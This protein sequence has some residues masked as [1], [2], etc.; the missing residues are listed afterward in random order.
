[1]LLNAIVLLGGALAHLFT[2]LVINLERSVRLA[3]AGRAFQAK[4]VAAHGQG[5]PANQEPG[6]GNHHASVLLLDLRTVSRG[7]EKTQNHPHSPG[8]L[9]EDSVAVLHRD[10][11]S[12]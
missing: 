7:I 8:G 6:F 10:A 3:V 2:R 1:G 11:V 4:A 5:N 12:L 9:E